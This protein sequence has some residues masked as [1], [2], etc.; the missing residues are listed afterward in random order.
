M[1]ILIIIECVILIA[2]AVL[3]IY[4]VLGGTW[5]FNE[6]IPEVFKSTAKEMRG[7]VFKV[8]T[9]AVIFGLIFFSIIIYSN[10]TP[11]FNL[12]TWIIYYGTLAIGSIFGLRALGEFNYVGFFKT[13]DKD[14]AFGRADSKIFSPL[15]LLLS[16]LSFGILFL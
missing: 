2:I 1:I 14:T 5:G 15:C 11:L 8:A 4:W 13:K 10:Y 9:I 3:H 7:P 6:A 12:P 16:M